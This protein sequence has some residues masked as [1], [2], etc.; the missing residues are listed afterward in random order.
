M[1]QQE[2]KNTLDKGLSRDVSKN[3]VLPSQYIEGVNVTLSKDGQYT[4]LTNLRGND[5][6]T[7]ILTDVTQ[8]AFDNHQILGMY[9]ID[10]YNLNT[11]RNVPC[12]TAFVGIP[13]SEEYKLYVYDIEAD[14][15]Y[16]VM[17]VNFPL[18]AQN[19]DASVDGV[20]FGENGRNVLYYTD[21]YG[22]P[23]KIICEYPTSTTE[24][25]ANL[26]KR[27]V[28]SKIVV[29]DVAKTGGTLACGAYQFAYRL[30][31]RD[32]NK[33]TN[34]SLLTNPVM[35]FQEPNDTDTK[36]A[37]GDIGTITTSKISLS[38]TLSDTELADYT[39]YQVAVLEN[40]DSVN[41]PPLTARLLDPVEIG[42]NPNTFD[43]KSNTAGTII[44]SDDIVVEKAAIQSWKTM[45][46]K[47][48]VLISGNIKYKDLSYDNGEP[49]VGDG[50][51]FITHSFS[52]TDTQDTRSLY[53]QQTDASN[54]VGHFRDELYRYYVTYFDDEGN[55]SR[56]KV[57][58]FSEMSTNNTTTGIDVRYP[59][60]ADPDYTIINASGDLEA[61]GLNI[62]NLTGHPTWAKGLAIL[63]A[64]R[65]KN[66]VFQTPVV[67][68]ILVQPTEA[69]DNYPSTPESPDTVTNAQPPVNQSGTYVPKNFFHTVN[70]SLVRTAAGWVDWETQGIASVSV[71]DMDATMTAF[72]GGVGGTITA[73]AEDFLSAGFEN[74]MIV[75]VD[76]FANSDT[77]VIAEVIN[78]NTTQLSLSEIDGNVAFADEAST[79]GGSSVFYS[80][81]TAG[82]TTGA[83]YV[84]MV[85]GPEFMFT[86]LNGQPYSD[87][88]VGVNDQLQTVDVA[89]LKM[90]YKNYDT[91]GTYDALDFAKSNI[92]GAFYAVED[93]DYYYKRGHIAT[94]APAVSENNVSI[95][96]FDLVPN[97][98][99][100]TVLSSTVGEMV[101]T[102]FGDFL[103]LDAD[104]VSE[105]YTPDNMRAGIIVTRKEKQD[106]ARFCFNG[107][108]GYKTD[109]AI[110][111][112]VGHF[113]GIDDSWSASSGNE[114]FDGNDPDAGDW[115]GAVEIVNVVK[116]LGDDR[117]GEVEEVHDVYFTGA[118]HTFSTA[119]LN[120]VKNK[121][122]VQ[123]DLDVWG[124]DCYIGLATF[125][126]GNSVYSK[127]NGAEDVA[128][129]QGKWG[130]SYRS[131][132]I[133]IPRPIPVQ[134]AHQSISVF[135]ESE[136]NVEVLP[137]LTYD[138]NTLRDGFR[139]PRPNA[140]N[141]GTL[142]IVQD[143]SYFPAYSA[144]NVNKIFIPYKE[145]DKN[146]TD[147]RARLAY[148]DTKIYQSDLEGFDSF[149]AGNV[150]D[151]DESYGPITKLV[152]SGNDV[153][154]LQESG[155]V[156]IPVNANLIESDDVS[157]L[158]VRDKELIGRI[159][160][161]NTF[162]GCRDIRTVTQTPD[163][164]I[165]YDSTNK[166]L[167]N[168]VSRQGAS[169]LSELGV[170]DL[171]NNEL[172]D[173]NLL[174]RQIFATY[175]I[176]KKKYFLTYT[177]TN[178]NLSKTYTFNNRL[179]LWEGNE[180]YE[181]QGQLLASAYGDRGHYHL[182]VNNS[183]TPRMG[184]YKNDEGTANEFFGNL[185]TP[186]VTIIVNPQPE[187]TKTFDNLRLYST[188]PLDV[189]DMLVE[190]LDSSERQRAF[191]MNL[192]IEPREEFYRLKVLRDEV[193]RRLRGSKAELTLKWDKFR[194]EEISLHSVT[195]KFRASN[196][197]V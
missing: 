11:N 1:A 52:G 181:T 45:T 188:G 148:S 190:R 115:V 71:T 194:D 178:Q 156:Y 96:S 97:N 120:D 59:D 14:S 30:V 171:F 176:N 22:E 5:E 19:S 23:K 189:A 49:S 161:I 29:S 108:A 10:W 138:E 102:D 91:E 75:E 85:F 177:D 74:G 160:Y 4:S 196:R 54:N 58:D 131:A 185:V 37:V 84:H 109:N 126:L 15:L 186:S 100:K 98:T 73:A 157:Q 40:L 67:P 44:A 154:G 166:Q 125:K 20:I 66:I 56:P 122:E 41:Y 60:R 8:N 53:T 105:G 64:E 92:F 135:L 117:Y 2:I 39:H 152:L 184:L 123:V 170:M 192:D 183:T 162:N 143:Y 116:G 79:G 83:D 191:G 193:G 172:P 77:P 63:R 93:N 76:G 46:V 151:M 149:K 50:S 57:L 94:P 95:A 129:N 155:V 48:N 195:T 146:I 80:A 150:Y 31:N 87:F 13:S 130:L 17:S 182:G 27:G 137:R 78:V 128:T 99:E 175:D 82:S 163:G 153:F 127:P 179:G 159:K 25:N 72:N 197:I 55:F 34:Y 61:I 51:D 119:E 173:E 35:V 133:E 169:E 65:K 9:Y 12:L 144:Q 168:I 101:S 107:T 3:S 26:L 33:Y 88:Q 158:A 187:Y 111:S 89:F 142:R 112:Q 28:V 103:G 70:R 174:D 121:T 42:I 139:I 68:S 43:Y 114:P 145:F 18:E 24:E 165:F 16:T 32:K 141:T 21:S 134:G 81:A 147:Y 140:T 110:T 104:N 124:G 167:L 180:D 132:S 69:V 136:V 62:Q 38:L 47:D 164:F 106:A 86:D 118:M 36:L 90:V 7:A 6:L 113:T